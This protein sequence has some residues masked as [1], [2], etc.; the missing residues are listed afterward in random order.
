MPCS[1]L[2]YHEQPGNMTALDSA[3]AR[4]IEKYLGAPTKGP[5]VKP[6]KGAPPLTPEE[7]ARLDALSPEA[8]VATD[9]TQVDMKSLF[10][11][12]YMADLAEV[13]LKGEGSPKL[14]EI[15]RAVI[16]GVSGAARET[17]MKGLAAIVGIPP[18]ADELEVD[19]AR[20][21]VIRKQQDAQA[22]RKDDT[23][24]ELKEDMHPEFMASRGQLMFGKVLG[25]AFGIHEVFGSLLSPT[26]GL[27]GPG[28]WL[29]PG[30]VKA[31]HLAPDNPVALHGT[32]HDAAGYLTTF[33]DKGPGYNYL[34]SS[35]EI[36]G[37]DSPMSG[38]I[39]GIAH[40]IAEAGDDYLVKRVEGAVMAVER[41]LK[42]I[43]DAVTKKVEGLF[44]MFSKKKPLPGAPDPTQVLYVVDAVEDARRKAEADRDVTDDG[45]LGPG[46]SD[47]AK[48]ARNAA[49]EFLGM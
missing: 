4:F 10:G 47:Q 19:Y 31:G 26:G 48:G 12:D 20:F 1:P 7:T 28:N 29:I 34:D 8:L 23:V 30:V 42:G 6:R 13:T 37:T 44:S 45:D 40:W 27:V 15:M 22:K 25:D 24:T 35:I 32:V 43:R 9:L 49:A 33:H 41:G 14:A 39:S 2:G 18:T 17:T 3:Q 16:K 38:Q 46:F 36:L 11:K 5:K 21:L